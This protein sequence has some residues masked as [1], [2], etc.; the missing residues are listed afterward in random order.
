MAWLSIVRLVA[1]IFTTI[2]G[3]IVL[4]LSADITHFSEFYFEALIIDSLRTG[5]FTSLVVFELSWLSVLS[6]L[7]VATGAL[8]V[9]QTSFV[10]ATCDFLSDVANQVCR[11]TQAIE[12]FSF[13]AWL[14]L[15][16][17][18]IALLA[19]AC[20]NAAR[21]AP[22]W[23]GAVRT[24]GAFAPQFAGAAPSPPG[25]VP[26]MGMSMS[27]PVPMPHQLQPSPPPSQMVQHGYAVPSPD[28]SARGSMY[29]V[30]GAA[31]HPHM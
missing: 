2:C 3:A 16:F 23:L 17:Y 28:G 4:S 31:V 26:S 18:T 8:T 12:A 19:V 13:L 11:E 24:H 14:S 1:L 21:G 9:D 30:P 22:I 27:M 5:A 10:F 7:W 29:G 6:V 25:Q 15:L 20:T